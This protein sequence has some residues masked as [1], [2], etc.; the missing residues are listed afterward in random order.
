MTGFYILTP[1]AHILTPSDQTSEAMVRADVKERECNGI[2][3]QHG[4][5]A[6]EPQVWAFPM[7]A[8]G[9]L[10]KK[11]S[12]RGVYLNVSL[13]A[14][15]FISASSMCCWHLEGSGEE[16]LLVYWWCLLQGL[17]LLKHRISVLQRP[18]LLMQGEMV[19]LVNNI[20]LPKLPLELDAKPRSIC[21]FW[22]MEGN[23]G[24]KVNW[25]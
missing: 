18:I 8:G 21:R 7:S 19:T 5:W 17:S 24:D 9:T 6:D 16:N 3:E 13:I 11:I 23:L 25:W 10:M 20:H 2:W 1:L 22:G 15:S 12:K 4:W 14:T